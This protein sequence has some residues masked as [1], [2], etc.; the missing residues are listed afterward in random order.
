MTY[1]DAPVELTR[2]A[3]SSIVAATEDRCR[4]T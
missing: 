2:Y 4:T 1:D 3:V